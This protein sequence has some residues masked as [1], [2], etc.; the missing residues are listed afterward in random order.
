MMEAG[1]VG[2]GSAAD[3][4]ALLV[5]KLAGAGLAAGATAISWPLVTAG[6]AGAGLY[7]SGCAALY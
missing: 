4:G 6:A 7:N 3:A 5:V 2:S 1:V